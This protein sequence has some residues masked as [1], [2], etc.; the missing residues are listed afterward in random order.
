MKKWIVKRNDKEEYGYHS[1]KLVSELL[2]SRGIRDEKEAEEFLFPNLNKLY[3]P[4]L[5]KN[6]DLA[7][8]RIDKSIKRREKIIIYGD[9]DVD[10]ITS[11]S[12]LYRALEKL[13]VD[14]GYYIPD[15][16][17]EGYGINKKAIQYI[18]SL[19]ANLIITVD[20]G[21]T[22]VDEANYAK[23]LGMDII[24]TDHHE[25]KD[26]LPATIVINP[27]QPGCEYPNKCLAG[28]GIAFKLVQALWQR[29]SLVGFEDF[30]DIAAIGTIADVVELKGEN[31][32]I[33]SHGLEKINRSEKCGIK[34][35]KETCELKDN[36]NSYNV[37]FQLAPRLNAVGRLSD[38]KIA[39]DL[40]VT[41][42]YDKALQIAK[43]LDNEN[44]RRQKIEEDILN[45]ALK[46]IKEIENVNTLKAIVLVSPKWHHGVVGIV[47]SKLVERLHRPVIL[48]C[49]DKNI[50]KGS[51]RS[52]S[53]F[54]L[55]KGLS[56]CSHL[57]IKFGGHDMAAGL[58]L[59]YDKIEK[60]QEA[61]NCYGDTLDSEIFLEKLYA[62]LETKTVD[63]SLETAELLKLF[64]P[65]GNGN[66]SPVFY[67]E[68]LEVKSF[69]G[70]GSNGQHL[71]AKFEKEEHE[72][73]GIL[74][75]R[76]EQYLN[77]GL[78]KVD[79]MYSLDINEWRNEKNLQFMLKDIRANQQYAKEGFKTNYYRYVKQ[80]LSDGIS[81]NTLSKPEFIK[82][83]EEFLKQFIYLQKGVVL[84]ASIEALEEINAIMG[85]LQ[86]YANHYGQ[87]AQVIFCPAIKN[88]DSFNDNVLIYD[89]LP[90]IGEYGL[91]AD[92]TTGKIYN[93][94]RDIDDIDS[95]IE[96]LK[97]L[98]HIDEELIDAFAGE[99]LKAPLVGSIQELSELYNRNT[100][101]MY[102]LIMRLKENNLCEV[103]IKNDILK[104]R[105][106]S[107]DIINLKQIMK[108]DIH[109]KKLD[110]LKI[111]FK[112][113]LQG[114]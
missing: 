20:C 34:A 21:I 61:L 26:T 60:L 105:L 35:L 51:G 98:I 59:D 103:Y 53:G 44:K 54:N 89:F 76:A 2:Y 107:N 88:F 109:I 4:F 27:K 3:N 87:G 42:D 112:E 111:K 50:C 95:K 15:R 12:I 5:L 82:Y 30:L 85:N 24:I 104:I 90:S 80:M 41:N 97:A 56:S 18:K 28:C 63:V 84:V 16:M 99:L 52:I 96:T 67:M 72:Y 29:Y 81:S 43:F 17:I 38:A 78:S 37:A 77:K 36:V 47:A 58:T 40:F 70:I 71:K 86:V 39:V 113:V 9:Y 91:L 100:Y 14:V 92:K 83:D 22:S 8:D 57:L 75:N 68:E 7:I 31:R 25:C 23:E 94:Y 69:K 101:L 33:V 110:E 48:L 64:E 106:I 13:G 10:G 32:I 46:M 73:D 6:M 79:I 19:Q 49:K 62:E 93:F 74:F 1:N 102:K 55:F 11:T 65:Y 66:Y 45:D 108:E 114:V